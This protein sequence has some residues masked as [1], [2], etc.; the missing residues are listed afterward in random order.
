M[1]LQPHDIA[2]A[3]ICAAIANVPTRREDESVQD[4]HAALVVW[5][6]G[7]SDIECFAQALVRVATDRLE[8]APPN[9]V[10]IRDKPGRKPLGARPMTPAERQKRRRA[11]TVTK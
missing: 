2:K 10:T 11:A 7:R 9:S 5:A 6:V 4:F 8:S 1:T 3:D